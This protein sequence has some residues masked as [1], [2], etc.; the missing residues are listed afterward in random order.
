MIQIVELVISK[1]RLVQSSYLDKPTL[2]FYTFTYTLPIQ[3]H[4]FQIVELIVES[5]LRCTPT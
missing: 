3:N 1:S 5:I 2:R 4:K